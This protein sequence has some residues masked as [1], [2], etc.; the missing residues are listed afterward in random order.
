M[1]TYTG[2]WTKRQLVPCWII[3]FLAA[4]ILSIVAILMLI[5]AGV[6]DDNVS[7]NETFYGMRAKDIVDYV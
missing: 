1:Q 2:I 3:Q 4:G 7:D 6:I 5:G